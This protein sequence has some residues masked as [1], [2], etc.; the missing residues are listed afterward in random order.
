MTQTQCRFDFSIEH[1][2]NST[3]ENLTWSVLVSHGLILALTWLNLTRHRPNLTRLNMVP[4]WLCSTLVWDDST[5]LGSRLTRL[6]LGPTQPG[7]YQTSTD[8]SLVQHNWMCVCL[9][10]NEC[11]LV[12]TK[13]NVGWLRLNSTWTWTDTG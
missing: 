12:P 10:L 1:E 5:Q 8:L 9:D 4:L 7:L 3:W 2:P 11:G 13:V 6:E